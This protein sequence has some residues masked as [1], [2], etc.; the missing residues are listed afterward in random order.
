MNIFP[1]PSRGE[2]TVEIPHLQ[3]KKM[4]F[5]LYNLTGQ[6]IWEKKQISENRFSIDLNCKYNGLL[7]AVLL[8]NDEVQE[9]QKILIQ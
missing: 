7:V 4:R 1:N 5:E 8:N 6:K 2:I 9:V 3:S